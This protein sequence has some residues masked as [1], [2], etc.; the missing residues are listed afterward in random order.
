MTGIKRSFSPM[1]VEKIYHPTHGLNS[2]PKSLNSPKKTR[3][4]KK[5]KVKGKGNKKIKTKKNKNLRRTRN[6]K[7]SKNLKK[8]KKLKINLAKKRYNGGSVNLQIVS[9]GISKVQDNFDT[10]KDTIQ[11]NH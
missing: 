8:T 10:L 5:Y 7:R 2:G 9:D 11:G 1:S 6:L 4:V 3:T